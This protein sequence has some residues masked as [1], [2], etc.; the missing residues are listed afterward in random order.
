MIKKNEYDL[1]VDLSKLL[2][3]YGPDIFLSLADKFSNPEIFNSISNIL[4]TTAKNK[5]N[6]SSK[7]NEH[8][9]TIRTK[10]E[11]FLESTRNL[12]PDKFNL[13]LNFFNRFISKTILP[14]TK[15]IKAFVV[16]NKIQIPEIK[17][18][19]RT[20][21]NLMEYLS[22]LPIDKIKI[23]TDIKVKPSNIKKNHDSDRSLQGWTDIILK[24]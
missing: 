20:V 10:T 12:E 16:Y 5:P 4:Y 18:R 19:D 21:L 14:N 8:K 24:K 3:K 13:L 22:K 11:E 7:K 6:V 17:S 15:D 2:K 9:R 23:M 1:L